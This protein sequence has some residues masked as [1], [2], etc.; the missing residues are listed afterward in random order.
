[1]RILVQNRDNVMAHSGLYCLWELI[2][3]GGQSRVLAR[4]INPDVEDR[5]PPQKT[6]EIDCDDAREPWLGISLQFV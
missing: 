3:E 2:H 1:M 6:N 5:Q 4:W